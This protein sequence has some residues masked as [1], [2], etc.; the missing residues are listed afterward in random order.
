MNSAHDRNGLS[1]KLHKFN[2]K[3]LSKMTLEIQSKIF[4][5]SEN[6]SLE[7]LPVTCLFIFEYYEEV[8]RETLNTQKF[9]THR[10]RKK[11][12]AFSV[13]FFVNSQ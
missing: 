1:H 13:I 11:V 10:C 3:L 9:L 12:I 7:K 6:L 2:L 5:F 4:S 8:L